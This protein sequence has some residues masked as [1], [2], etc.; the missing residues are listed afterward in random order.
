MLYHR[1]VATVDEVDRR[2][3]PTTTIIRSVSVTLKRQ[4]LRLDTPGRAEQ[5]DQLSY[6]LAR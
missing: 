1:W 3:L 2:D 5:L 6:V 4:R